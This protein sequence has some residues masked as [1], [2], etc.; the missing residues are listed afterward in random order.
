MPVCQQ[1]G[2]TVLGPKNEATGE[3][4]I[5]YR[6]HSDDTQKVLDVGF[7][8]GNGVADN[9]YCTGC[10]GDDSQPSFGWV[11]TVKGTVVE[12]GQENGENALASPVIGS[13]EI[14]DNTVKCETSIVPP[15]CGGS[16]GPVPAVPPTP[17]QEVPVPAPEPAAP[18]PAAKDC[19]AQFCNADLAAG[20]TMK[21]MVNVP[22]GTNKDA[23]TGCT[24][25]VEMYYDGDAWIAL[26]FSTD[27]QMV[28]S[29]AVM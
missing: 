21:Y 3:H 14:L 4:C 25:S 17:S 29:D 6:I 12:M 15:T 7:P 19:T 10:T 22:Q 28:G 13:I 24:M 9:G 18:T 8:Y 2:Y 5:G 16:T 27:G 23:C 1:S 26:G 11:A 20:L